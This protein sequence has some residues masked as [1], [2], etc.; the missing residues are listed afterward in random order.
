MNDDLNTARALAV[1]Q[2]LLKSDYPN[3]AKRQS[4]NLMD[5]VLGLKLSEASAE[6]LVVPPVAVQELLNQ[7]EKA[8]QAKDFK[9]SDELRGEIT[10]QGYTIED[11]SDGQRLRKA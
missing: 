9:R 7:R 3:S 11:M 1:L 6:T 5:H 10:K 2:E 8:R 4:V